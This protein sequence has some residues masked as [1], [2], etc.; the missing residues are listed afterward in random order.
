MTTTDRPLGLDARFYTDPE[1]L[2]V[3]LE[4]IFAR[5]WV[6]VGHASQV[7][8]P[9]ALITATV[10]DEGVVVANDQ[11]TVRAFY[12]VCQHR[13]HE[14]VTDD[15]ATVTSITCPYHAWTYDL[16]GRLVHARGEDVG[17][18]C[19]PEVRVEAMAGFLFVNLDTEAPTLE[20]TIPGI[21]AELLAI[22]PDAAERV[23]TSR[24]THEINANW[25]VAVENYNECYHCPNVHKAF[26]AGVVSPGSYRIR[27][28]GFTIH[29]TAEGPPAEKSGYTRH[30]DAND[31][32]S[33]FTWPVSSIQCYPGRVLNTFRWVPLTVDRTLLVREWW[34][35]RPEPT[36]A[37]N[38]VIELD[39]TTT[40]AEDFE[41]MD[42]VQ[43]GVSSRGYR[44]GPLIVD[45]SGVADV[46]SEN[47]VPHL[48]GLL[49]EALG[50][51]V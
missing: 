33:F 41:L 45:P 49:R 38:E 40:V 19:V 7:S 18:I 31:Y 42:S 23:L 25:K 43:R 11:G 26:T 20:E 39:W 24:R 12:N 27:P 14:L 48:H 1:I 8:E 9:G 13:G 4:L 15:A 17:D 47:T 21:E 3:E 22:A 51:A 50:D 10:G 46:H 37:Q 2:A 29:H 6:M 35:D 34:F 5:S 32:G 44:P 30:A 16:G 36:P 28:R